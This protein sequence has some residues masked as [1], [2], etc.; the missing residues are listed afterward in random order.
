MTKADPEKLR[1]LVEYAGG[2]RPREIQ[3]GVIAATLAGQMMLSTTSHM[4]A[5]CGYMYVTMRNALM[6]SR[7]G[8]EIIRQIDQEL[9]VHDEDNGNVQ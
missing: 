5:A 4:T 6:S 2:L 9:V 1:A 8:R 7:R 3:H